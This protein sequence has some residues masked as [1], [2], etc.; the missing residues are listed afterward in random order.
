MRHAPVESCH[1]I[2]PSG[3]VTAAQ[4]WEEKDSTQIEWSMNSAFLDL[5]VHRD[6]RT[7]RRQRIAFEF[8]PMH[9]GGQRRWFRCPHCGRRVGKLYLPTTVRSAGER[10]LW[11][12]CRQCYD[13]TYEQRQRRN[14][15]FHLNHRAERLAERYFV[16]LQD[17]LL[18][19]RKGMHTKTFE[20]RY[21]QYSRLAGIS[22]QAA[23]E[24]LARRLK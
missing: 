21:A 15:Y 11:F 3:R 19:P 9:F 5:I 23:A 24:I 7:S 17:G 2:T 14:P 10:V 1:I 6:G 4:M 20:K 18:Y 12:W 22:N 13:L 16:E 8:T